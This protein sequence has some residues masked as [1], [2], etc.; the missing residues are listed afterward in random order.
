VVAKNWLVRSKELT[1]LKSARAAEKPPAKKRQTW[2]D[3][4][5]AVLEAEQQ[6]SATVECSADFVDDKGKK[7]PSKSVVISNDEAIAWLDYT[8]Q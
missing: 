8:V 5:E 4:I 1:S 3:T 6:I 7:Q 2:F